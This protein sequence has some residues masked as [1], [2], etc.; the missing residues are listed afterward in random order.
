[1]AGG[2]I[3]V[4]SSEDNNSR[5]RK[6]GVGDRMHGWRSGEVHGEKRD[7]VSNGGDSLESNCDL[8][9]VIPLRRRIELLEVPL[10]DSPL[11]SSL[12]ASPDTK[13]L[14]TPY[15]RTPSAIWQ[16]NELRIP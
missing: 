11:P 15:A 2:R 4:I 10:L 8:L 1:M 5:E 7:L 14:L 13:R 16:H 9:P 3:A 12:P 6:W